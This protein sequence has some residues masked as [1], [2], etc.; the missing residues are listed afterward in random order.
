MKKLNEKPGAGVPGVAAGG[1]EGFEEAAWNKILDQ[2]E[3]S[4]EF[5]GVMEGMMKQLLCKDIIQEPLE[6]M[7]EKVSQLFSP[8]SSSFSLSPPLCLI[9]LVN[10]YPSWLEENKEK[11]SAEELER[12]TK[13]HGSIT[14]LCGLFERDP[15]NFQA[16]VSCLQ[17]VFPC[18]L[19]PKKPL[20]LCPSFLL[21]PIR[22]SHLHTRTYPFPSQMGLMSLLFVFLLFSQVQECGQPPSEIIQG[23]RFSLSSCFQSFV[24]WSSLPNSTRNSPLL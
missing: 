14:Q 5:G 22:H 4:P 13:Q 15:D 1:S 16:I 6:R 8:S 3:G 12:Y 23:K 21:S 9:L 18:F 11:L 2:L 19:L 20:A 17:E 24:V 10:Q 7:K